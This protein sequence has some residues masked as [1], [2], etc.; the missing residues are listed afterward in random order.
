MIFATILLYNKYVNETALSISPVAAVDVVS[1]KVDRTFDFSLKT[2]LFILAF[3]AIAI[4]AII[5]IYRSQ[6][7]DT[8]KCAVYFRKDPT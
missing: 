6:T 7:A 3:V 4:K 5:Q 1:L 2:I 8:V